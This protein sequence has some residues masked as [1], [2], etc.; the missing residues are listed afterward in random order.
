[1]CSYYG[2]RIQ[3]HA[4]S[5]MIEKPTWHETGQD[6]WSFLKAL[7]QRLTKDLTSRI[8]KALGIMT[9][10][11]IGIASS[12]PKQIKPSRRSDLQAVPRGGGNNWTCFV[13]LRGVKKTKCPLFKEVNP[14]VNFFVK[15]LSL[16]LWS[17]IKMTNLD[18]VL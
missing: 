12:T 13:P 11:L 9:S 4:G 14:P 8:R 18:K 7:S 17:L 15:E 10:L 6:R 16:R 2:C 3:L 1:M 5:G